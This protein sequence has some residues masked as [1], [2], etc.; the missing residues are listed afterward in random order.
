[1]SASLQKTG[2]LACYAASVLGLL[3]LGVTAIGL[4]SLRD[5]QEPISDPWFTLMESLILLIVC[6]MTITMAAIYVRVG[7]RAKVYALA[8]LVFMILSAGI[9]SCVHFAILATRNTPEM[10]QWPDY[11][12][13]FAFKWPSVVYA[14]DILAWDWFFALSML[15]T[16]P[17]IR[18]EMASR[19]LWWLT[20]CCSLLSFAGLLGVPLA[21]MQV[22][23]L[24]IVGYG[25]LAPLVFWHLGSLFTAPVAG[26]S[27]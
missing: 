11:T 22:R 2:L 21:D 14:L 13:I 19:R 27:D 16:L 10:M 1:M 25:A 15:F 17:V 8:A 18:R 4:W 12:L 24:G 23:N 20:L 9:T 5:P 6:A 26:A 3:Y 7:A